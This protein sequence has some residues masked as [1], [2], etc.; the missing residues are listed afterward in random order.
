MQKLT[1]S[2]KISLKQS[3]KI[4]CRKMPK[5]VD[6]QKQTPAKIKCHTVGTQYFCA[7]IFKVLHWE[8]K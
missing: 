7:T 4:S 6:L 5:I 8:G 2:K 1:P 3:Q